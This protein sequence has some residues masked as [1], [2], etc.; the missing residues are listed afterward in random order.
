MMI[1]R[2]KDMSVLRENIDANPYVGK[3]STS[4]KY[5]RLKT[6]K[7]LDKF[8]DGTSNYDQV[9]GVT[10]GKIYEVVAIEGFGDCEDITIIDDNGNKQE[11]GDFFFEEV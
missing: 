9:V 8:F 2:R 6:D 4:G 3:R 10:R 7:W 11:L 5:L 1:L